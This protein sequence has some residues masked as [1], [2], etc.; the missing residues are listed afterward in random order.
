MLESARPWK[1][2]ERGHDQHGQAVDR[3]G[4]VV[5]RGKRVGVGVVKVLHSKHASGCSQPEEDA[6]QPLAHHD[7]RIDATLDGRRVGPAGQ[8]S[9]NRVAERPQPF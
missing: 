9:A 4:Q 6:E 3:C 2:A 5:N 7:D 1:V 8:D